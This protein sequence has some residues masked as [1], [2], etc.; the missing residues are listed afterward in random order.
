MPSKLKTRFAIGVAA[1]AAAVACVPASAVAAPK[2]P[3][4]A[5]G[6]ARYVTS[7][8][9]QLLGS[10][11]QE[12]HVAVYKFAYSQTRGFVE[13][14]SEHATECFETQWQELPTNEHTVGL[15]K[16]A[17]GQEIRGLDTTKPYYYRIVVDYYESPT[18]KLGERPA[19]GV[20]G[21][22]KTFELKG[23]QLHFVD[24]HTVSAKFGSAPTLRGTLAGLGGGELAIEARTARFPFTTVA[25][26][27][28]NSTGQF[29]LRL[30]KLTEN[31]GYVV[32]TK[33]LPRN[34]QSS[35]TTFDAQVVVHLHV[36]VT[37]SARDHLSGWV[38][39]SLGGA[40]V[41]IQAAHRVKS[42][43]RRGEIQW[44]TAFVSRTNAAG[45]FSLAARIR[46]SGKYR[47]FVRLNPGGHYSSGFSGWVALKGA[48]RT[49][50]V[51]KHH[52]KK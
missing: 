8:S 19:P 20:D 17:V 26:G 36:T 12:D 37:A 21:Q 10:V 44:S 16:T 4:G 42:G 13:D 9:A 38:S 50:H 34:L 6:G 3:Y 30:P 51:K 7:T 33:T 27:T 11:T 5:T 15:A 52:R 29:A 23:E 24:P 1:A 28:T 18:P 40:E 14:C 2:V 45:H 47:A 46:R 48:P 41:I 22:I 39:P 31:T 32:V 49:R 35:V 25:T 43:P